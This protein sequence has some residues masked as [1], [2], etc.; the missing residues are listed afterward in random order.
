MWVTTW[1]VNGIRARKERVLNWIDSYYPTVL[2]LQETRCHD[3]QFPYNELK[4]YYPH[5]EHAGQ[6]GSNGVAILSKHKI[7]NVS[8][9]PFE[10]SC[11][12]IFGTVKDL[13]IGSVYVPQG[14]SLESDKFV[15]K[16]ECGQSLFTGLRMKQKNIQT[17]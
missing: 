3:S 16:Q 7:E 15:Y 10:Q 9:D 1:N 8:H 2:C 11:R 17:W 14:Q 12:A 4:K 13:R 5:I 6:K